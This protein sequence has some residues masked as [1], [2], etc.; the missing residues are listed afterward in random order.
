MGFKHAL[1][2]RDNDGGTRG[3]KNP[4]RHLW[5]LL[6]S[7]MFFF[8]SFHFL[9]TNI[10]LGTVLDYYT[11]LPLS[12]CKREPEGFF[13]YPTQLLPTYLPMTMVQNIDDDGGMISDMVWQQPDPSSGSSI[14][15]SCT[16][17][18]IVATYSS[19][20]EVQS[21]VEGFKS[22]ST[23]SS[24]RSSFNSNSSNELVNQLLPPQTI[25]SS[26]SRHHSSTAVPPPSRTKPERWPAHERRSS[27]D[28]T[29]LSLQSTKHQQRPTPTSSQSQ[30]IVSRGRPSF[31]SSQYLQTPSH[32]E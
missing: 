23:S 4:K 19:F 5:R 6:G 29:T 27:G 21:W 26:S 11:W 28:S 22:P 30:P 15:R 16:W 17:H 25:R 10:I 3:E 7:R 8:F 12:C 9:I 24:R 18:A 31:S 32:Y 1:A 2:T 13:S 20:H 14:A